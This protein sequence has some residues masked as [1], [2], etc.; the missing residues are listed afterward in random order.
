MK[1]FNLTDGVETDLITL[2]NI[3]SSENCII[4]AFSKSPFYRNTVTSMGA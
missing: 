1:A 3:L 4:K 2:L